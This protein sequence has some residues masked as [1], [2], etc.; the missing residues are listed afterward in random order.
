MEDKNKITVQVSI[1]ST[2]ET[3]WNKWNDPKD[4]TKWYNASDDWYTPKAENDLKV[5]GKF[6]YRMEAKDGSFGFDFHGAYT[7]VKPHEYLAIL[8]GD[9]R[10][11]NVIFE[12]IKNKISVTENFE[13]ENENSKKLQQQG[14]QAI[15]NNW[16]EQH[17]RIIKWK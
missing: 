7:E 1:D 5:G 4:I 6:N 14:W 11:M 9:G 15:L 13:P 2:L 8:L 16:V 17:V 3:V 10:K 12:N